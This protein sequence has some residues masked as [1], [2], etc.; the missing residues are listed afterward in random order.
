VTDPL[1][2]DYPL[3]K[4]VLEFQRSRGLVPDGVV[5]KNTIIHLNSVSNR[6]GVPRLSQRA[7]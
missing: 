5:G 1:A 2:F 3:Q 7:S 6:A 4:R